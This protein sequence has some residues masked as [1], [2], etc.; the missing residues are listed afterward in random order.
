MGVSLTAVRNRQRLERFPRLYG[1]G[2]RGAYAEAAQN[3][4]D[5]TETWI[6]TARAYGDVIPAPRVRAWRDELDAVPLAEAARP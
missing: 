1:R 5:A 6:A 2:R 4:Q 3:G